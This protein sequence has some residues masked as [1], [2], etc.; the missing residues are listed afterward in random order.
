MVPQSASRYVSCVCGLVDAET[1]LMPQPFFNVDK[2]A[3]DE[4]A[5]HA[6]AGQGNSGTL[7]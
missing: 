1:C 4:A 7:V 5:S 2:D 6:I 3:G